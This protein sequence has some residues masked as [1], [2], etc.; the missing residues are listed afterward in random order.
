[1]KK[2][3]I[4]GSEGQIGR[5]LSSHLQM[6]GYSINGI[7]ILNGIKH[8]L[9]SISQ[10]TE[11]AFAD[12]D[13]VIFLAYDVGGSRYLESY[14]SSTQFL[15]NNLK[16]MLN[17]FSLIEKY[18]K[19]F[20]FASSQMSNMQFSPYGSLKLIGEHY[21]KILR[22]KTIKF[23]NVFGYEEDVSKAHVI[24]D[25]I[26]SALIYSEIKML[27][28][29]SEERQFLHV[30]ECS[31]AI[32]CLIENYDFLS[33][34]VSYDV[35]SF[36]YTKILEV[37]KIIGNM[38]GV[39]IVPGNRVD[40]IQNSTRNEPSREILRFWTPQLSI[41]DGIRAVLDESRLK[42]RERVLKRDSSSGKC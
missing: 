12:T 37:A 18:N 41:E 31:K 23:W 1:M 35:T 20:F 4:L 27:T 30:D 29:G 5:P 22:G 17:V 13:M 26:D 25:F 33:C 32:A 11:E 19:D 34:E 38:T 3:L 8:D 6:K 21:T 9:R 15:N 14:Q 36:E 28:N 7:D 24:T 39:R 10:Q 40:Q 42:L 16:I 2:V